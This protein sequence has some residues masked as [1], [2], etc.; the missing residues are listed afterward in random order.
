VGYQVANSVTK[1]RGDQIE[2]DEILQKVGLPCFV[3]PNN[4]GS[5]LG[6]SKV[7]EQSELVAA[8]QKAL[9]VDAQAIIE[10]FVSGTEVTCGVIQW[11]G[12][13]R[14]LPLTEIVTSNEFF[15]FEAKYNGESQEITPARVESSVFE[16]VQK[17]AVGIYRDLNCRGM[18]RVDFIIQE[19]EPFVI[20]VNT[21]PGFSEASIIPQQASAVGIDKKA[22]ITAVIEGCF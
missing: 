6:T 1:G 14:A 10:R 17:L 16:N 9:T 20:E 4:G 11:Q 5:S 8:I 3:K 12:E 7:K 22:L 19:N 13:L 18:I 21:V 15:D 2:V